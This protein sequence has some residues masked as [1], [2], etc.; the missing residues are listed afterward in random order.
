MACKQPTSLF[1]LPNIVSSDEIKVDDRDV[2]HHEVMVF[3]ARDM[4]HLSNDHVLSCMDAQGTILA[5][6]YCMV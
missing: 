6:V 3:A 2:V 1:S 4:Q 5:M